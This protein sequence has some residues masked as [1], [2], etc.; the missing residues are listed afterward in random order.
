MK[1]QNF[2]DKAD[3]DTV[4]RKYVTEKVQTAGCPGAE[5]LGRTRG[6]ANQLHS[7]GPRRGA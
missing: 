2:Q 4:M 1:Q 3:Q 6:A 7:C 5:R